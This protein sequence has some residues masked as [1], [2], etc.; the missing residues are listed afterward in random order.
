M[1][2]FAR[3][4]GRVGAVQTAKTENYTVEAMP[5]ACEIV[6]GS[7]CTS[8]VPEGSGQLC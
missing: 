8:T 5:H 6:T 4:C 3:T 7:R 1:E 2:E